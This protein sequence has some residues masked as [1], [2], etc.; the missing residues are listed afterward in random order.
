MRPALRTLGP[1]PI[2]PVL[3][4]GAGVQAL[5]A[6]LLV[7]RGARLPFARDA[8]ILAALGAGFALGL[9]PLALL[10]AR[11]ACLVCLAALALELALALSF[12]RV[13]QE[14]GAR[15]RERR[16]A[17]FL[18]LVSVGALS[19]AQGLAQSRKDEAARA[20]LARSSRPGARL[21]LVERAGC[22][23]CEALLLDI[24]LRPE[25]A[26][27]LEK[28][29]LER[30]AAAPR[31]AAPLLIAYDRSGREAARREGFTP[32]PEAY[33]SVLEAASR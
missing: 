9:Q 7:L 21:V 11:R 4:V 28:A 15:A 17:F 24:L 30:R 31:E 33:A 13:A 32:D 12:A 2:A 19:L 23:Y 16:L 29:G 27:R 26:P 5:S 18:A 14:A 25:V 6:L 1:F 22:P 8:A 10:V 3:L 20:L